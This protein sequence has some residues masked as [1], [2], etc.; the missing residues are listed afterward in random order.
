MMLRVFLFDRREMSLRVVAFAIYV[1][2]VPVYVEQ[3]AT[4]TLSNE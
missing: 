1:S 4:G 3:E 2:C